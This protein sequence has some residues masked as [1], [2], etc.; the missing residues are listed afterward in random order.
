PQ[1]LWTREE[2]FQHGYFRTPSRHRIQAGL[3]KDGNVSHWH[4]RMT[5]G[6]VIFSNSIKSDMVLWATSFI[7]D[8]GSVR[9]AIPPYVM[10]NRL[11]DMGGQILPL[12][13]GAMRGLSAPVNAFAIES[14]MDELAHSGDMDPLQFR[15][16]QL[17]NQHPRLQEV[18]T[19]VTAAANWNRKM[20]EHYGKGLACGIYKDF[21][22]TAAVVEVYVDP[23][24]KD[25]QVRKV[26]CAQDCG[27]II[28]PNS[29]K[30]QI[31]GNIIWGLSMA[32]KEKLELQDGK[33]AALNFDGYDLPRMKD[34]PEIEI[35]LVDRPEEAP[36]GSG[37]P[38]IMPIPAAVANAVFSATGKRLTDLPLKLG[39][40]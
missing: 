12:P 4:H 32:L 24:T 38:T 14:M 30:A 16:K 39:S 8:P 26:Y 20:P 19:K 2:S 10:E 33:L 34:S 37:E 18:L 25:I 40:G 7:N 27:L 6:R 28:N 13:T 1:H 35:I 31:E 17:K 23:N 3:D 29:V 15:M 9:G 5:S 36:A 11:I 21:A 22:F